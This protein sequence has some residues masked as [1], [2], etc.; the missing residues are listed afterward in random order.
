MRISD[1][2]SD[3]CSSDLAAKIAALG[4]AENE[5]WG[6]EFGYRYDGS[7]VVCAEPD[8]PAIDPLTYHPTTWPGARLPHI[9]LED[10]SSVHDKLGLFFTLFAVD[11]VDREIGRTN[12]LTPVN[13][14][15]F[16]CR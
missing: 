8:P 4:N 15:Q 2:S 14:A 16:V 11:D 7:P 13:N 6:V 12:V 5:S 10:G 9:F 1:W 3:V